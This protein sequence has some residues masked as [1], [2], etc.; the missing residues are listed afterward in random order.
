MKIRDC[1]RC[2]G[3]GHLL[4]RVEPSGIY[5]H[6][7]TCGDCHGDGRVAVCAWCCRG[8]TEDRIA[9]IDGLDLCPKCQ[10]EI[11]SGNLTTE[12]MRILLAEMGPAVA[13]AGALDRMLP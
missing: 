13:V 12:D 6:E 8:V 11:R 9:S 4:R 3:S 5:D 1:T 7:I 10:M 2:C